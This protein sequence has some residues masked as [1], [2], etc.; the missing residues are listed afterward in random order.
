M[1]A[2]SVAFPI[3]V[4][5]AGSGVVGPQRTDGFVELCGASISEVAGTATR[6]EIRDGGSATG[7]VVAT[8]QL[9]ANASV[10]PGELPNIRVSVGCYVKVVNAGTLQGSLFIR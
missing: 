6:V 3:P 7:N 9:G 8:F 5:V 10:P 4:N 1:S 2:G